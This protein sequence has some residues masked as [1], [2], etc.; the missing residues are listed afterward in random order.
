MR[1]T[2]GAEN[3]RSLGHMKETWLR[4]ALFWKPTTEPHGN[5]A[6]VTAEESDV[7]EERTEKAWVLVLVV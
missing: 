1:A 3:E 6:P 7:A 5:A 2:A 4:F